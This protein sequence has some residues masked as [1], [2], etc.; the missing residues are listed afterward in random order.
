MHAARRAVRAGEIEMQIA[1]SWKLAWIALPLALGACSSLRVSSDQYPQADFSG[2]RSFAWIAGD[3]LIRPRGEAAQLSALTVRRIREAIE[4]GLAAK[5][6][7]MVDSPVQ[8]SFVVAFTVGTRDRIDADSYPTPYSGPWLW[9]HY[10]ERP[11]LRVYRE[12][13][14]S[15]DIFDGATRQPVW[16]GRA[17][18]E[19]T[20]VDEADPGPAIQEA[21][22]AI[23]RKFPSRAGMQTP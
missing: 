18:K 21:V 9:G 19:V 17:R 5:G 12:G 6:Y 13:T 10:G 8:A 2:Y 15:V 4:A 16:Q 7:A 1:G 11:D 3:P 20:D 22:T 23:L 14:L